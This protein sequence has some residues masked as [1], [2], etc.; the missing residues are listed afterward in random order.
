MTDTTKKISLRSLEYSPDKNPLVDPISIQVKKRFVKTAGGKNLVDPE[1]G[2]FSAMSVIHT[3]EEKDDKEFVKVFAEGVRLAFGLTK[4]AH[5]VFQV[6][7][8]VYEATPMRGGYADSIYLAWFDGGLAGRNIGMSDRTF[9]N[10]LKELLE[11]G[12]LAA[13]SPNMFWVNPTLFFKGDRVAFV[14]EYRRAPKLE[15]VERASDKSPQVGL[16]FNSNE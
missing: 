13:K 7:L 11:K 2:E 15:I 3:V 14:R 4:T 10:G 9:H 6:V 12:F 16:D 8:D 5:K 1:T